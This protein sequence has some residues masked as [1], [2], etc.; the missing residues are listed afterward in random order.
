M[1]TERPGLTRAQQELLARGIEQLRLDLTDAASLAIEQHLS[2]VQKWR[3]KINLVSI[4]APG[5]L[6]THHALDS[7]ALLPY[8]EQSQQVL[9][10]GTGA[11]FPGMPLAAARPGTHFT[12][13]DSRRRRIEFLRLVNAQAGLKNTAL[14]CARVEEISRPY[15]AMP[16]NSEY[17]PYS[18][19]QAPLK[20]DTLVARAVASLD[21]LVQMTAPLRFTGQRL[22]AMKGQYPHDELEALHRNHSEQ[23]ARVSV[24]AIE[25]P[26][27]DAERHVVVIEYR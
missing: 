12:L 5:E 20:F 13:L 11:G 2:L 6:I 26:F 8:I 19:V 25:V 3:S 17:L 10:I 9:D 27:L 24:D 18:A 22:I 21:Q 23:I 15:S 7:L 14:E 4:A 1:S 16:E